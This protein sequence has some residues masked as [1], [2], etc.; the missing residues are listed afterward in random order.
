MSIGKTGFSPFKQ[1]M[2]AEIHLAK[3]QLSLHDAKREMLI[4]LMEQ[5]RTDLVEIKMDALYRE[6]GRTRKNV[7]RSLGEKS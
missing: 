1:L 6:N 7:I 2:D 4:E 5:G 3:A